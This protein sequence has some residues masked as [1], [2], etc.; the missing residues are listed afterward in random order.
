MLAPADKAGN[1]IIVICKKYY[2]QV[3]LE[4]LTNNTD[5]PSTYIE[6]DSAC[7]SSLPDAKR[8]SRY[9]RERNATPLIA[10]HEISNSNYTNYVRKF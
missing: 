2:L 4:E 9:A 7:S 5:V 6:V 10:P 1:N 8:S 3:I